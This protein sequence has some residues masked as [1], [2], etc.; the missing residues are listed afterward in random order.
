MSWLDLLLSNIALDNKGPSWFLDA[1]LL[2][3][4]IHV[5]TIAFIQRFPCPRNID[6]FSTFMQLLDFNSKFDQSSLKN[7][8]Q[9]LK[10]K[11]QV[12]TCLI[13]ALQC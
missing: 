12:S 8:V 7:Q 11:L 2:D 5:V 4:C 3:V 10:T 6:L 1:V 9:E 13:P